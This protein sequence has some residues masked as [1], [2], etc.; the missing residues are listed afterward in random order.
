MAKMLFT[1]ETGYNDKDADELLEAL[2]I[3]LRREFP[4]FFFSDTVKADRA[5][6]IVVEAMNVQYPPPDE[7]W[8]RLNGWGHGSLTLEL[9]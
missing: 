6:A 7:A 3:A 5:T 1:V 9:V 2:N 4:A 8:N